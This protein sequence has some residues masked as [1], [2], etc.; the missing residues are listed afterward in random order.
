[1]AW[2]QEHLDAINAAIALG[3]TRVKYQDPA[4]GLHDTEYSSLDD[5]L[6]RKRMIEA[7]LGLASTTPSVTVARHD[8]DI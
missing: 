6:R 8:R 3:A 4:G 5:L 1:M 2:T 7:E